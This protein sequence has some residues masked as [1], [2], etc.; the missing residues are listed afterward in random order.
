MNL[1]YLA[2]VA[3]K[4]MEHQAMVEA[5][6]LGLQREYPQVGPEGVLG[7]ELNAYAAELA[8]VS[9]WIRHIQWA[10]RHGFSARPNLSNLARIVTEVVTGFPN[11]VVPK[12]AGSMASL[13]SRTLTAL[14]NQRGTAQGTWLD[15]HTAHLFGSGCGRGL[16]LASRPRRR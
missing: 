5:E 7:L 10:R 12:D 11:R 16:W 13:R 1:L 3:L 4:D 14:Y 6:V 2:L 9:I 8:R 15:T